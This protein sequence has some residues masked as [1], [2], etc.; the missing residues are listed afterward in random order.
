MHELFNFLIHA[1][2]FFFLKINQDWSNP[3]LDDF[4]PFITNFKNT[5]VYLIALLIVWV[6]FK[7][8]FALKAILGAVIAVGAADLIADRLIKPLVHRDR[9]EFAL[10]HVTVRVPH[11]GSPSFPSSHSTNAFAAATFLGLLV[12]KQR[13]KFWITAWLIA[14]SRVYCGVHFPL[15]VL[16]GAFL[17]LC[18]AL[19]VYRLWG[20]KIHGQEPVWIETQP[21]I[22]R[23]RRL[24]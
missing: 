19:S 13:F 4:F 20:Y 10:Q 5:A 21:K 17:G 2:K 7:K 11:Q 24:R 22:P 18:S 1:D 15:D 23:Y 8:K 16:G 9:P 14:Y 12:P 6:V 3:L